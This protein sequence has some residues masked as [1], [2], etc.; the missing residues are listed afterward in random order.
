MLAVLLAFFAGAQLIA[1]GIAGEYLGRIFLFQ[2]KKPQFVI[3]KR[4]EQDGKTGV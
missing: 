3:R 1:I 4:F 2:N